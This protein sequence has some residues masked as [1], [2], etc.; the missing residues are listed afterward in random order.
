MSDPRPLPRLDPEN[1][2][3]WTSGAEGVLRFL[4]CDEC[5]SFIHPPRPFCPHC[6]SEQVSPAAVPGT[7]TIDTYTINRQKWHPA[8][9]VPCVIARIAIDGA[10]GVILTSNVINTA[11]EA[12]A[13]G[14]RVTVV[15][16]QQ[17]DVFLPFFEKI[18]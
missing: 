6:L 10:P 4:H 8:M 11:P 1:R 18:D 3:F 17:D 2:F 15:F 16:E 9:E 5:G 12:V 13:I 14:D 7:G